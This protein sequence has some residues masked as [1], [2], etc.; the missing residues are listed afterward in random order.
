MVDVEGVL[1]SLHHCFT[2]FLQFT[3]YTFLCFFCLLFFAPQICSLPRYPLPR[4]FPLPSR[5]DRFSFGSRASVR[6]EGIPDINWI[7]Y[8]S[9]DAS[10]IFLNSL[11]ITKKM[12][13]N[14]PEHIF[15]TT[16]ANLDLYKV[17]NEINNRKSTKGKPFRTLF[18]P[19]LRTPPRGLMDVSSTPLWGKT[20]PPAPGCWW[21][22][23]VSW[24]WVTSAA[25]SPSPNPTIPRPTRFVKFCFMVDLKANHK[26]RPRTKINRNKNPNNVLSLRWIFFVATCL[27]S[28]I[29]S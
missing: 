12:D 10:D 8:V 7:L 18:H 13:W 14:W 16:C 20:G 6:A 29:P 17:W 22:A 1:F 25:R 5:R 21:T 9:S 3:I 11:I 2:Q 19:P 28:Y 4:I 15:W 27:F 23:R 26:I 24:S